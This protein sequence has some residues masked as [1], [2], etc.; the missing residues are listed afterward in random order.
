MFKYGYIKQAGSRKTA[1]HNFSAKAEVCKFGGCQTFLFTVTSITPTGYINMK[2]RI[3]G[4]RKHHGYA[5]RCLTGIDREKAAKS[6][7]R[8]GAYRTNQDML[9]CV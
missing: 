6:T 5:G 7:D 8:V 2:V 9:L 3:S 4:T 1:G